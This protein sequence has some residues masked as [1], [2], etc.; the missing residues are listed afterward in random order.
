MINNK[1][2]IMICLSVSVFVCLGLAVNTN[3]YAEVKHKPF[4]LLL[5]HTENVLDVGETTLS[6]LYVPKNIEKLSLGIYV[7]VH[8]GVANI[9]SE[10]S[11]D[12]VDLNIAGTGS[13]RE[14]PKVSGHMAGIEAKYIFISMPN[15]G[16][17]SSPYVRFQL[18]LYSDL[19]P[20]GSETIFLVEGGTHI[21]EPYE[22]KEK[23]G[24]FN[25]G[26]GNNF[27][28]ADRYDAFIGLNYMY[29]RHEQK[30]KLINKET[31]ETRTESHS[32]NFSRFLS[33]T[34]GVGVS[35]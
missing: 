4:K 12:S 20:S 33:G 10:W 18:P 25:L 8:R 31:Q 26:I 16:F 14:P 23:L 13:G 34:L 6:V 7:G 3:T 17:V 9:G 11:K 29:K 27:R 2:F 24:S 22:Y 21:V 35:F 15:S 32:Q 28:F 1:T 19:G 5:S 30:T